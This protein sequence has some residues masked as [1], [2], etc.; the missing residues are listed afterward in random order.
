MAKTS[1][2]T[3]WNAGIAS[4]YASLLM[5]QGFIRPLEGRKKI[6]QFQNSPQVI[7]QFNVCSPSIG[8]M[9]TTNKYQLG[10]NP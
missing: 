9:V 2:E 1:S 6:P 5:E 4:E 3:G 8:R 7:Y 10:F